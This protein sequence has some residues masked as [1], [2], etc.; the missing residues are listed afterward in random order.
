[1]TR[2]IIHLVSGPSSVGKSTYIE[3]RLPDVGTV[4]FPWQL[5]RVTSDALAGESVLH[6]N[7]L[8]PWEPRRSRRL[9]VKNTVKRLTFRT[10]EPGFHDDPPLRTLFGFGAEIRAVV[11]VAPAR[12]LEQRMSAREHTETL[13]D[14]TV[15]YKRE[16]WLRTL[17]AC[18]IQ[19]VYGAWISLLEAH[20]VPYQLVRSRRGSF[21]PLA[22][23]A[24]MQ[25]VLAGADE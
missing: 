15:P 22:D 2:P 6:Y 7:I 9:A 18:D 11:L 1:M 24:E 12:C 10:S 25:G 8:R 21:E 16:E 13:L 17:A 19:H 23:V 14:T 3:S 20:G 5:S 4:L